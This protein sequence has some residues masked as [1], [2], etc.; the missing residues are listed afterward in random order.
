MHSADAT[1]REAEAAQASSGE[2]PSGAFPRS[3]RLSF[4]AQEIA[5]RKCSDIFAS[6]QVEIASYSGPVNR[7]PKSVALG[8]G[9]VSALGFAPLDWWPLTLVCLALLL[10]LVSEAPN[11]RS[12]LAR[13]YWFG[14]GHFVVG[15]NWIAGAFQYQDA[16][17][18]WLGWIAVVLLSLYLAVYPAM[19][20]GLAWRWGR[21]SPAGFPLVFAAGWIVAEYLRATMFTGFAWNPL[22]VAL[23]PTLVLP[24]LAVWI[25]TYGLSGLAIWMAGDALQL[26]KKIRTNT[27]TINERIYAFAL[28]FIFACFLVAPW[29]RPNDQVAINERAPLI[30]VVQPNI[31]QQDKHE[32]AFDKV[33][34]EK[35]AG[36]TGAPGREP[37]LILWP[38]A[39][40][41]DFLEEEEWA[42]ER[43]AALIGPQD[44]LVTG[45]VALVEDRD[46]YVVG[47]R[48]SSF[49]LTP[50]SE[51][52]ARYDKSHLVPYGEY[53]P[54]RPLL[55]AIG[56][57]R[58]VPGDLDFWP[59]PGPQSSGVPGFGR[60]GVQICYEIIFSGHVIDRNNRPD[61]LFNP[62][63]DA[64]FGSWG[65]PQHLAQAR[66]RAIEEGIPVV[67]STP[68]GIS[69]VIDA[70]G[71]LLHRLPY[72][73]AGYIETHLPPTHPPTLFA[74][75]GN[76]LSL[77]CAFF[78]GALGIALGR[79]KR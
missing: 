61:F 58:L 43:L 35:L 49:V 9:L 75:F 12:A 34:F 66:L 45:G 50:G 42:R 71:N 59:G 1:R 63:N 62:S 8:A 70:D 22:G 46:G 2:Q 78:L 60:M 44:M 51:I 18:K 25:G 21:K 47:A 74:R 5:P 6:P 20:S 39:A 15:L 54:M 77:G 24:V 38:E 17:P 33:N 41:P 55:S 64:W 56:L 27:A 4:V 16:M 14:V 36:L 68:T 76:I 32:E 23:L 31:G 29:I 26:S 52:I 30:R 65:P 37:R 7:I 69:A 53:L 28:A 72:R 57:S 3:G 67:R 19:A 48:N 13:G 11:L 40:V 79:F 73:K 10:H